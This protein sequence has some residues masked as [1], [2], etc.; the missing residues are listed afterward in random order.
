MA[1]HK[2]EHH[3]SPALMQAMLQM[4]R[5]KKIQPCAA[6]VLSRQYAGPQKG[7]IESWL[8]DPDEQDE[9]DLDGDDIDP[10]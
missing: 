9:E 2:D 4:V 8:F 10:E 7:P 3:L 6:G 5:R 1:N